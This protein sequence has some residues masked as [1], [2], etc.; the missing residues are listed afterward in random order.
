M[1]Q[2]LVIIPLMLAACSPLPP[3]ATEDEQR[4]SVDRLFDCLFAAARRMDDGVSDARTIAVAIQPLC[5]TEF[6]A[7]IA[8]LA[9]H[10]P[11]DVRGRVMRDFMADYINYAVSAVLVSRRRPASVQP[12]P[13]R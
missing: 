12:S 1:R 5:E 9:R 3:P 4:E 6:R 10:L 11:S 8:L 7:S 2:L 13:A